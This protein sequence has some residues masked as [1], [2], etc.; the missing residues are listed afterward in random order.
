VDEPHV[1]HAV[2]FVEHE[3]FD[4]I[5]RNGTVLHQ[6]EQP[7]RGRDQDVDAGRQR[8]DL[9][10]D[11]HAAD[12]ERHLRT[13]IAAVGPKTFDDLGGKLAR[14]AQDQDAAAAC[15]RPSRRCGEAIEDR[16]RE[17][18]GFAGSR[19]R[20][21]DDVARRQHLRNGLGLDRRWGGVLLV[22]ERAGDGLG[23]SE[24]KKGG[25]YGI[26][27]RASRAAN[28]RV[29]REI[30]HPAWS[31]LSVNAKLD[32]TGRKPGYG[33]RARDPQTAYGT[34]HQSQRDAHLAT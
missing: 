29:S 22:G 7:S 24:F 4:A 27:H 10:I 13:Q 18:R 19:L 1:E 5:E 21:A 16:Q 9:G 30:G 2:G 14:R 25:Q 6:V 23:E 12:G 32:E 26:F 33:I 3:D 15:I 28:G 17:G 31:G 8:T 34:G 20:D 11:G